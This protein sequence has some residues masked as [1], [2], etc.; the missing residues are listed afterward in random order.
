MKHLSEVK[1]EDQLRAHR[2]VLP[3]PLKLGRV[4]MEVSV[5]RHDCAA[6]SHELDAA[7]LLGSLSPREELGSRKILS[8]CIGDWAEAADAARAAITELK[9]AQSKSPKLDD[10]PELRGE[11]LAKLNKRDEADK[12]LALATQLAG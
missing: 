4:R 11:A 2:D 9:T 6:G 7:R 1:P 5:T 8:A 12:H 3:A 10:I